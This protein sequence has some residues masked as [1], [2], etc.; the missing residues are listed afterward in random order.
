MSTSKHPVYAYTVCE[1]H[2]SCDMNGSLKLVERVSPQRNTCTISPTNSGA[3]SVVGRSMDAAISAQIKVVEVT[4]REAPK[5]V[6]DLRM[7][8]CWIV[9]LQIIQATPAARTEMSGARASTQSPTL[10][11]RK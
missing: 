8:W 7:R 10:S 6:H 11:L 3:V 1:N 2:C 4:P 5:I 9:E